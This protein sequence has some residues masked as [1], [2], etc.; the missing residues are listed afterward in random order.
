MGAG[1]SSGK[2]VL[3]EA[4]TYDEFQFMR[5]GMTS[6]ARK[7]VAKNVNQAKFTNVN[8]ATGQSRRLTVDRQ[9]AEIRRGD[10]AQSERY[11]VRVWH[12]YGW[13]T[14]QQV[15]VRGTLAQAEKKARELVRKKLGV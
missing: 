8:D 12:D 3:G 6:Q 10:P 4:R 9:N 13:T 7:A 1:T 5:S 15:E 14:P 2:A 11:T